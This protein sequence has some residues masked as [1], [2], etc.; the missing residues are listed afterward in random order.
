LL[1]F[2]EGMWELVQRQ[3]ALEPEGIH[4]VSHWQRV[5]ENGLRLAVITGARVEVVRWFALLH[6]SQRLTDGRDPLHGNRAS[7]Y[8]QSLRETWIH[9]SEADFGLL[10]FACEHHTAGL[11]EGDITVQ[12]CWD[13]DRLDL[14]RVGIEPDPA[15]LCT[16]ASRD[17][18]ILAWAAERSAQAGRFRQKCP[19]ALNPEAGHGPLPGQVEAHSP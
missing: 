10:A 4:G 2:P 11:T 7:E 18:R 9:L 13:A 6:D 17:P 3:F 12:T 8:A 1:G 19:G 15:R 16:P 5:L 14:F